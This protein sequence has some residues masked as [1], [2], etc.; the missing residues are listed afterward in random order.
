MSSQCILPGAPSLSRRLFRSIKGMTPLKNG[1]S[2]LCFVNRGRSSVRGLRSTV[3]A[4]MTVQEFV[5]AHPDL[6]VRTF[7]SVFDSLFISD[8]DMIEVS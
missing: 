5:A 8:S 4:S 3:A 2:K 1:L 7:A 6:H